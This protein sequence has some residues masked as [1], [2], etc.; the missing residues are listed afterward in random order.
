MFLRVC[1]CI[2]IYIYIYI[3]THQ[4]LNMS[5]MPNKINF[6]VEFNRFEL[7]IFLLLD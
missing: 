2:Y 6:Q 5:I 4:P 3:Y 1:V 7:S